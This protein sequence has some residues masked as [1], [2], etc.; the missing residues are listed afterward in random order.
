MAFIVEDGSIV[1]NANAY[2]TVDFYREYWAD[3]G[4][5]VT[6]PTQTDDQIQAAIILAT[7]Y[8]NNANSW[9]GYI[10]FDRQPLDWPRS[11]VYDK[12]G[13]DIDYQSIPLEVKSA[14]AEYAYRSITNADGLLPDPGDLGAVKRQ[15]DKV[16]SLETETE[17]QDNTGGYFGIKEY[18]TADRYLAEFRKGGVGGNFAKLTRC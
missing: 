9:K 5:D 2:I 6:D 15:R 18:P 12:D 3:R 7:Q 11:S 16:G 4:V 1:A 17:Y 14:T 13:R 10:V 8:I